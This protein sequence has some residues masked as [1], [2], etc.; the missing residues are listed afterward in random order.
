MIT[1]EKGKVGDRSSWGIKFAEKMSGFF[2]EGIT[3]P[4]EGSEEGKKRNQKISFRVKLSIDCLQEFVGNPD[5]EASMEGHLDAD[6]LGE[7]LPLEDGRFNMFFGG[8]ESGLRYITYR[9]RFRSLSGEKFCF[10]G[11]KEIHS[12]M[13]FYNS[14]GEQKTLFTKIYRGESEEGEVWGSGVL[15]FKMKNLLPLVFSVRATGARSLG[16]KIRALS[17]FLA[18]S[19]SGP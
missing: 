13:G 6:S 18:F 5:Y 11:I 8:P 10:K 2:A 9:F 14:R 17:M 4:T 15:K 19:S 12:D 16:D 7:G 1:E 3:E